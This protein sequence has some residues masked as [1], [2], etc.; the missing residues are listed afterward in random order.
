ME[1]F[2]QWWSQWEAINLPRL[3]AKPHKCLVQTPPQNRL[4]KRENL[5]KIELKNQLGLGFSPSVLCKC[6]IVL[7]QVLVKK[8][9]KKFVLLRVQ[10]YDE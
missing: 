6:V 9:K 3:H 1:M 2:L 8:K 10:V 5:S 4:A 7:L